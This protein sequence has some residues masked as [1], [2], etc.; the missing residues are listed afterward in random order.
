MQYE[1]FKNPMNNNDD[2][3]NI[4][5][6]L[7]KYA[8]HWKWFVLSVFL[9]ILIAFV[10]LRYAPDKYEVKTTVLIESEENGVMSELSGF[11]NLGLLG[12]ASAVLE[13]EMELLK[14]RT[15]MD[16]IVQELEGNVFYFSQTDIKRTGLHKSRT[17]VKVIFFEKDKQFYNRDTL[18]TIKVLSNTEFVLKDE[19]GNETS[20]H[21]FG[22]NV[23]SKIGDFMITP[24]GKENIE[25]N[26][27]VEVELKPLARVIENLRERILVE[28]LNEDANVIQLSLVS[29]VRLKAKELL[30]TLVDQYNKDAVVFK[31][32]VEKSTKEF[33]EDRLAIINKDLQLV[34]LGAES[35]KTKNKLTDI[36]S[37]ASLTL[38]TKSQVEKSIIDLTTELKLVEYVQEHIQKNS[39][40]LIPVNLGLTKEGLTQSTQKYNELLLERNRILQSSSVLNP[41]IVNLN[42]QIKNVRYSIAQSL[43]NLK[44]SLNISLRDI[45][46]E[47]DRLVSKMAAV[48]KQEREFRS[49]QRQQ[50]IIESLYLFLLEKR[51]ENAIALAATAPSAR[52]IDRAY[53]TIKPVAPKKKL[54]LAGA[55]FLGLLIPLAIL[56]I[57]DVFD[58]KLHTRKDL[59]G[60]VK[61]PI[62]GD[63]PINDTDEKIV[64]KEGSRSSTAEAF[65]LLRTNLDFM[66]S[67]VDS[68][69]KS[70]FVTSTISG[71]G[72]SFISVN[73]ASALALSGKKVALV[74]MDLR[75]PKITEYIGAYKKKG[76]TNYIK[77]TTVE[78]ED[79]KITL[80][81][82]DKLDIYSSGIIPPNPAELLMHSRVQEMFEKL[83]EE[84][85]YLVVDTAPVNL[86]TDTLMISEYADMFVY[87]ARA[88]FLDKRF[89]TTPQSLYKDKR[90]PNMAMLINGSDY[91]KGYGYGAYGA[92]GSY[93]YG[94][95]SEEK[96]WWKR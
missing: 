61:A 24:Q 82:H 79:L 85:D 83:R 70:L 56:Y 51:E 67:G 5:E 94:A 49:I 34:E 88:G 17:P 77:D 22:E 90:L 73:L 74:G 41:V 27:E 30:N 36:A 35:F 81:D 57:R 55:V 7:E 18:F 53:A 78:L 3:I 4:R 31:G 72:K 54:V 6:D 68:S 28:P 10:Y 93:G 20:I 8:Y 23:Q 47:E 21:N 62:L 26:I 33:I 69:C 1:E 13:D 37:E 95:S 80:K 58:T 92:Y 43:I 42:N 2:E 59:E 25:E 63:I 66:L 75:A 76:I 96:R 44:S 15:L 52:I 12:G 46:Q 32:M 71:E 19:D 64:V 84:Y 60:V 16:K 86:V 87:V 39:D 11:E 40:D 29:S 14:S 48:P 89:L 91:K 45:Q 38:Q 50:Q 65:R 9:S